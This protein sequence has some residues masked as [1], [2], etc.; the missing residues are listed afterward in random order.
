MFRVWAGL[1]KEAAGILRGVL[2]VGLDLIL[3]FATSAS[4]QTSPNLVPRKSMHR[5]KRAP[6][7]DA[8]Y[9]MKTW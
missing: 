9:W 6:S 2:K 7:K 1:K 4:S 8:H 3:D 5:G